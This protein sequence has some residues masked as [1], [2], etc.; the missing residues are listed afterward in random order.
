VF[1]RGVYTAWGLHAAFIIVLGL[2]FLRRFLRGKWR[3]MRVIERT[4][5]SEPAGDLPV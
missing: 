4:R 1:G 2:A 5:P 3:A